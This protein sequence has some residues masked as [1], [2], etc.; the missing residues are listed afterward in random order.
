ML[1]VVAAVA[2]DELVVVSGERERRGH[3]LVGQRPVAV[4][5]SRSLEPSCRKTR[6]GFLAVLRIRAS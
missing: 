1:A 3:L 5:L 4:A 2:E 6:I